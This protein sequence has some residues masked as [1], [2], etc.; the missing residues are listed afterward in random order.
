MNSPATIVV[1]MD[2]AT[3]RDLAIDDVE[4][5]SSPPVDAQ[6][7]FD[8]DTQEVTI[9][10]SE[11]GVVVDLA[12][13]P[14]VV[15]DAGAPELDQE[16]WRPGRTVPSEAWATAWNAAGRPKSGWRCVRRTGGSPPGR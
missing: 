6:F 15:I 14:E 11:P 13:L 4:R 7:L 3:L 1:E 12:A 9:V 2:E 8:K 16:A 5:F 10:P